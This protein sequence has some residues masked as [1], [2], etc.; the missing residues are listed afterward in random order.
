MLRETYKR[1]V[2][3]IREVN[4]NLKVKDVTTTSNSPLSPSLELASDFRN[5]IITWDEF[6]VRYKKEMNT[7]VIEAMLL[8]IARQA[9]NED[10]YLLCN[11]KAQNQECHRFI[12]MDLIKDIAAKNNIP[13][14]IV[15][16]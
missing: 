11:D 8:D 6:V 7:P 10:I 16:K 4:P 3:D 14:E 12:L 5:R 15:K 9:A 1:K 2:K 13:L